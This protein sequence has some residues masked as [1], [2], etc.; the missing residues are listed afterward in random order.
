M[1][2]FIAAVDWGTSSFRLW[3]LDQD[4]QVLAESRSDEGMMKAREFGFAAVLDRHLAKVSA[5]AEL[6]VVI[7]GMA[8]AKQGWREANYLETPASLHEL[9]ERSVK[10]EADRPIHILPGICQRDARHPDVMRG[11][12]TQL[13]GAVA[14]GTRS[15]LVCMPGTHAKWVQLGEGRVTRFSTFMTGELYAA[16]AGHTILKLALADQAA[17]SPD[18]P[19][20]RHAVLRATENPEQVTARLFSIR[21]GP[22]LG[23]AEAAEGAAKLS[24]ELIG[25]ELAG[26]RAQFGRVEAVT[27]VGAGKLFELYRAALEAAGVSVKS[28][29]ADGA[30]RAGLLAAGTA[31][32]GQAAAGA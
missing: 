14:E 19:A 28:I 17:A 9:V 15:G 1:T 29:D 22:L 3:L 27:L 4:G 32:F 16:I 10:I 11:E 13:L 7:C 30:V 24:G 25:L 20:F 23:L 8:G 6:P 21:S 26:A 12:E 18:D 31:L 5:P 2:P